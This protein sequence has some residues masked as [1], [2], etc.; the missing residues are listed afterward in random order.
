VIRPAHLQSSPVAASPLS[1]LAPRPPPTTRSA[2][3]S[4]RPPPANPSFS[5]RLPLAVAAASQSPI[6]VARSL[7]APAIGSLRNHL[8]ESTCGK[9]PAPRLCLRSVPRIGRSSCP[10]SPSLPSPH[11]AHRTSHISPVPSPEHWLR[12]PVPAPRPSPSSPHRA[13]IQI[14]QRP[15]ATLGT[16][17]WSQISVQAQ[18]QSARVPGVRRFSLSRPH[19]ER[20]QPPRYSRA[21]PFPIPATAAPRR[22]ITKS[23]RAHQQHQLGHVGESSITLILR[24][25]QLLHP[26]AATARPRPR[27][28]TTHP[29]GALALRTTHSALRTAHHHAP[30]TPTAQTPSSRHVTASALC[31]WRYPE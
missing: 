29:R 24:V 17:V 12:A 28:K 25:T 20:C 14:P 1:S 27:P 2:A 9:D 18:Q 7:I 8:I 21:R 11:I 5:L 23:H 22:G 19:R 30:R 16:N 15:P 4:A 6:I 13:T 26:G 3:P 10:L 31:P